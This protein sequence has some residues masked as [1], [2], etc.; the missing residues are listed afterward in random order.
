MHGSIRDAC[1]LQKVFYTI[2]Y[3][4]RKLDEFLEI[5]QHY[6][7]GVLFDVRRF[8]RSKTPWFTRSFLEKTLVSKG[9][10]YY[11]LGEYLGGYRGGYRE[12]METK[13]YMIG[14]E[15]LEKLSQQTL[16]TYRKP[17]IMCLEKHPR[18]CHR[19][20]IAETLYIRGYT[21][22]HILDKN[23]TIEHT[24]KIIEGAGGGI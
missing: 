17:A 4:G 16:Y 7:I 8:P 6:S 21:V 11:W 2:G 10:T 23:K 9:I 22:I 20:Y 14:I 3:G 13:A 12:Y 24:R 19:R 5:L 15:V 18:Y 1:V